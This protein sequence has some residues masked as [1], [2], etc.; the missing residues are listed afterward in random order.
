MIKVWR[1]IQLSFN[2]VFIAKFG[3]D[4]NFKIGECLAK[5]K[6]TKLIALR[7]LFA[8]QISCLKMKNWPDNLR[9]TNSNCFCFCYVT[10]QIIF[11]FSVNQYQTEKYFSTTFLSG[12]VLQCSLLHSVVKHG[13]F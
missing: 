7:T 8:L 4:K 9:M 5:M 2:C 13:N 10:S 11:D 12:G 3:S 6:A 1:A